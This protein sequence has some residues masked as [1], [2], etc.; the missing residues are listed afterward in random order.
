MTPIE[1]ALA[2][3][4]GSSI[5]EVGLYIV[6]VLLVVGSVLVL[7]S[8]HLSVVTGSWLLAHGEEMALF[9]RAR[10]DRTEEIL[11]ASSAR[12]SPPVDWGRSE[13]HPPTVETPTTE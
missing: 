11:R 8:S 1:S 12:L 10:H 5:G 3:V 13:G 9:R 7:M 4:A 2:S 6:A